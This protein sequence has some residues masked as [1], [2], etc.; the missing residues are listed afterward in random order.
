MN[1][2]PR[3]AL[4]AGST[5][6]PLAVNT[7]LMTAASMLGNASLRVFSACCCGLRGRGGFGGAASSSTVAGFGTVAPSLLKI[8]V[9]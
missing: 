9:S 2:L 1:V 4:K 7:A 8:P 5:L 3:R 6:P